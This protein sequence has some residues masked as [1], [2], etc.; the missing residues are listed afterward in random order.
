MATEKYLVLNVSAGVVE[1]KGRDPIVYASVEVANVRAKNQSTSDRV[2]YGSPVVK[3]NLI[4]ESTG[5]PNITLAKRL[6]HAQVYGQVVEFE[7]TFDIAKKK[8]VEQI[9]FVIFDAMLEHK[10]V[11]KAS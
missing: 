10:P 4:D 1:E 11:A 8:G 5:K 7:G 9:T 3:L 6:A 2:M